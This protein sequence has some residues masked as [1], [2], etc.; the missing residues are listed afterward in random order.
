MTAT[1][2]MVDDEQASGDGLVSAEPWRRLAARATDLATVLFVQWALTVIHVFFFVPPLVGRVHPEPWGRA[3]V[4]TVLFVVLTFAYEV[5][6][7]TK[8]QG[9]TP[10]KDMLRLQVV[11]R[12]RNRAVGARD[13]A[14]RCVPVAA[15]LLVPPWWL[16]LVILFG[17]G[18]PP[19]VT[20]SGRSLPD[21]VSATEVVVV[22]I[23]EE[24][25]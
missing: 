12:N 16:G 6:F 8:N 22:P 11:R 17:S 5:L 20:R 23:E 18:I 24:S 1:T 14:V 9:R 13:A 4:P 15:A 7:L 25:R 21:W 2:P 19:L 10:G 3:F